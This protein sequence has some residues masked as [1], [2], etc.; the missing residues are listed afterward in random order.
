VSEDEFRAALLRFRA[1]VLVSLATKL[2]IRAEL[3]EVQRMAAR[4]DDAAVFRKIERRSLDSSSW[5][6]PFRWVAKIRLRR[7]SSFK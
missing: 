5:K 7:S 6:N 4:D 2:N 3:D 1:R